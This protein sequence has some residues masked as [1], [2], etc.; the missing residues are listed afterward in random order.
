MK[1]QIFILGLLHVAMALLM[2]FALLFPSPVL[3]LSLSKY[4]QTLYAW[5][6]CISQSLVTGGNLTVGSHQHSRL[7]IAYWDPLV[8]AIFDLSI[9]PLLCLIQ[10]SSIVPEYPI[11]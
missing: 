3:S 10:S 2:F 1:D 9:I 8:L 11:N 5:E 4:I 6:I 7:L